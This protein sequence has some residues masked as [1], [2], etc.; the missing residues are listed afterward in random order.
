MMADTYE[1]QLKL[2]ARRAQEVGLDRAELNKVYS[3]KHSELW[4]EFPD[5]SDAWYV[6]SHLFGTSS[7]SSRD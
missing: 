4:V 5:R 2:I 3:A 1:S 6:L 7:V